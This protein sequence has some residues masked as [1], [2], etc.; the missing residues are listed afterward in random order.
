MA[1]YHEALPEFQEYGAALLG[2]SVDGVW[3]HAAFARERKPP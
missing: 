1:L 3:C 2:I